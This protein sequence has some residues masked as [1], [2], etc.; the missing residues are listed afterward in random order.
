MKRIFSGLFF[1]DDGA[2]SIEYAILASLIAVVIVS[3]VGILGISVRSLFQLV[4]DRYPS[5]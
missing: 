4:V 3:A 5:V 1:N 2:S